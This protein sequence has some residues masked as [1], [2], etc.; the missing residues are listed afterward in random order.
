M[1]PTVAAESQVVDLLRASLPKIRSTLARYR[2]PASDQD[3]LV[4]ETALALVRNLDSIENPP[5]WLVGCLKHKCLHYWRAHRRR[6][7]DSVDT[8]ILE[9]MA[10][11]S[12]ESAERGLARTELRAAL[13][14]I[15]GKCRKMLEMRYLMGCRTSELAVSFGYQPASVGKI[16]S[17]CLGALTRELNGPGPQRRPA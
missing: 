9:V 8:G 1:P 4:Q 2:I 7:Y 16:A 13:G 3:D 11:A 6:L 5:A 10:P 15:D 14:R 12:S 17:R